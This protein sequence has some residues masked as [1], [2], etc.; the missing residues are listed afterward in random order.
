MTA[1]EIVVL[2]V[3]VDEDEYI[4]TNK[5]KGKRRFVTDALGQL[6]EKLE[7]AEGVLKNSLVPFLRAMFR[8]FYEFR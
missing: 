1:V 7:E 5:V 3:A 2:V 4:L 6:L 8:K